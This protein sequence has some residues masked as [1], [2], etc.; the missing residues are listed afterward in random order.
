MNEKF[1]DNGEANKVTFNSNRT[2]KNKYV[3]HSMDANM[4]SS[5]AK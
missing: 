2:R 1:E 3:R 4:L 5:L